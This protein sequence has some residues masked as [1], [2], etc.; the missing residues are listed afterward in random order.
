[1]NII[2]YFPP[3]E[4]SRVFANKIVS[5]VHKQVYKHVGSISKVFMNSV[6]YNKCICINDHEI[7]KYTQVYFGGQSLWHSL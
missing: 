7:F 4:L 3:T 2:K 5:D 6:K 1:V